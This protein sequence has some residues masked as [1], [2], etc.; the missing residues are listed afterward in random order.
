MP[1]D[2][3]V[4]V[5]LQ[6]LILEVKKQAGASLSFIQNPT[7][8]KLK[9]IRSREDYVDNLKKTLENK[10]YFNLHKEEEKRQ[11]NYFRALITIAS[12]LER[13]ADFFER[14]AE[15]MT[16]V[17]NP[18]RLHLFDLKKYYKV[19]NRS[20]DI[21]LPALT[22]HD[23]DLAQEICDN[24]QILDDLYDESFEIIRTN[25]HKGKQVDDMLCSL[26]IT[27]YLERVGDSFLN[28]G[29][30][31]LDV[32]VGEKM[33]IKQFRYL[34]RGLES[35]NIDISSEDVAYL[36]VMN[37]RSGSRVAKIVKEE[38][39][40]ERQIVFYKEGIKEKIDQ[41]VAGL[42]LWQSLYPGRTPAVLWH[43]SRRE[44][45]TILLEYI[46]GS[47][48]LEI[49]INQRSK[50]GTCIKLLCTSLKD[51]WQTSIKDKPVRSTY[52]SQLV[53]RR[54]DVKW[55]HDH[56]FDADK[57]LDFM[58]SEARKME[59]KI[60][61]PFSTLIH[62]DFNV[63]NIIFPDD[64]KGLYYI[65]VHRSRYGDFTQDVSVFLVSNFRIP[66]FSTDIRQRLNDANVHLY[67]AA[68]RFA[69][70]NNDETFEARLALGLFRSLITSTR[71]LFDKKF[72][73]EMFQRATMILRE[74]LTYKDNPEKFKLR[75][76]FFQYG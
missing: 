47:D 49:L 19:I 22:D 65:D 70:K 66:I 61:A 39:D 28:I 33:G 72:S 44:R 64:N 74:L 51:L 73:A 75:K 18:K 23:L 12:N 62:G 36:P 21:I 11:V 34:R 26:F 6:F 10:S 41:E 4:N 53:T 46:E 30:A 20:L 55:V 52:I 31:I 7:K 8:Q 35:Q 1:I 37:T 67:D 50:A 5:D 71:F 43:A 17:E 58:L 38:D 45:S 60:S 14:I 25:L 24:E 68:L 9:K 59:R 76:E 32:H 16:Y 63:D 42:K 13:C 15:Q 54:L 56:L 48:L 57:D 29:E 2:E 27:R 69:R 40:G 3:G